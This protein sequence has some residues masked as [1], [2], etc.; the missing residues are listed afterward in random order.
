MQSATESN[1][2]IARAGD[3]GLTV[4]DWRDIQQK[5][6]TVA[7]ML[8]PHKWALKITSSI[9]CCIHVIEIPRITFL[10]LIL[11]TRDLLNLTQ[12]FDV[13]LLMTWFFAQTSRC[14]FV[15]NNNKVASKGWRPFSSKDSFVIFYRCRQLHNFI[16]LWITCYKHVLWIFYL[17]QICF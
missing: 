2:I 3:N 15:S 9:C 6:L 5:S 1:N 16:F 11:F 8:L 17:I 7:C 12:I 14:M 4:A 13:Y 10:V